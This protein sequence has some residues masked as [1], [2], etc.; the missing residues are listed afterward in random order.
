MKQEGQGKDYGYGTKV[1]ALLE[2]EALS[3][4]TY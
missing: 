2:N 4:Q 1:L 3:V